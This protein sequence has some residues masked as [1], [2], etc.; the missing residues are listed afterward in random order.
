MVWKVVDNSDAGTATKHG[1]DSLDKVS[2]LLR[3]DADVDDV[4]INSNFKL[5]KF[6]D[7]ARVAAPA[8]PSTNEGRIYVK[9]IDAN[10]DGVFAKIKKAGVFVEVQIL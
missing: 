3:G 5:S 4:N 9:Q 2:K 7:V 10:N 8:N 1:G 6:L